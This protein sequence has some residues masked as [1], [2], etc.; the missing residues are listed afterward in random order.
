MASGSEK[1]SV[2]HSGQFMTSNPHT[3]P[4]AEEDDEDVEVEVVEDDDKTETGTGLISREEFEKPVTFYKFGPKKTQ[5]IAIDISLNKLNKCI[6]HAYTKMTTPKWK[7]FKGLRL[8]WKQRIR[9]NNV[10]WRAYYMEFRRPNKRFKKTPFCYFAVPDD[11]TTHT[12]IEACSESDRDGG[13]KLQRLND[14]RPKQ[15]QRSQTPMNISTEGYEYDDYENFLTDSLFDSLNQPYMFPNPREFGSSG[16]AD[17]MQ[18]GLLSLQPSLEEIMASLGEFS[19]DIPPSPRED[20]APTETPTPLSPTQNDD[21]AED[22]WSV[23]DGRQQQSSQ[24][25]N[26]QPSVCSPSIPSTSV[27]PTRAEQDY[28]AAN[29]LIDYRYRGG[30]DSTAPTPTTAVNQLLT[31]PTRQPSS[32][33]SQMI[34]MSNTQRAPQ[35]Q[36][37]T[38]IYENRTPW[39]SSPVS[40]FLSSSINSTEPTTPLNQMHVGVDYVPQF[41]QSSSGLMMSPHATMMSTSSRSS[42]FWLDSPM[43]ATAQSPLSISTPTIAASSA[44]TLGTNG[45]FSPNPSLLRTETMSPRHMPTIKFGRVATDPATAQQT[46]AL[47]AAIAKQN[48]LIQKLDNKSTHGLESAEDKF[49][50]QPLSATTSSA[51]IPP[52]TSIKNEWSSSNNMMRIPNTLLATSTLP[53]RNLLKEQQGTSTN[54]IPSTG[55]YQQSVGTLLPPATTASTSSAPNLSNLYNNSSTGRSP[56][57]SSNSRAELVNMAAGEI[58]EEPLTISAPPS[59]KPLRGGSA[60]K[61]VQVQADSTLHPEERKRILHLH[62]EQNRRSA[63][64]DGFE[65]LMELVPDLYAGGVKPTNAVVL[66]KAADHIRRLNAA[67][68]EQAEKKEEVKQ[69]IARLNQKISALQS[70][71][72][73]SSGPSSAGRLDPRTALEA[74]YDRY[75]KDRSRKDH[76]FWVMARM[77]KSICVQSPTCFASQVAPE[78]ARTEE[79]AASCAEWMNSRWLPSELRPSASDLLIFLATNTNFLT[80]PASLETYV[81]DQLKAPL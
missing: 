33:T 10:I 57:T 26:Q 32:I 60:G 65:Q 20:F 49:R 75:T 28:A 79:I 3:E 17:I 50:L 59:V 5:S 58:K 29:L 45:V 34:M 73:T 52:I 72:P 25:H 8:H 47:Q 46:A 16:N 63:L 42:S 81:H 43:T 12:K 24:P 74:F 38:A 71:L 13:S 40:P 67:K 51:L 36:Y 27:Q 22:K 11:D 55:Y 1:T 78:D 39:K 61:Q 76:R 15:P 53:I 41:L 64:K 18:P 44:S 35:P 66:A 6:K 62:A 7:D 56:N 19:G 4:A 54:S 77:L 31:M 70:N 30:R 9:L 2:I 80:D 69:R 21:P 68:S 48:S 23:L 14:D 37:S